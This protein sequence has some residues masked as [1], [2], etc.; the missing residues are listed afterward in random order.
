MHWTGW[1]NNG[2]VIGAISALL[3]GIVIGLLNGLDDCVQIHT[4]S[5]RFYPNQGLKNT[6]HTTLLK[7]GL[8]G[9]SV[10]FITGLIS[11]LI[12]WVVEDFV[13]GIVIG[14]I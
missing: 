7:V 3:F 14:I 2:L 10:G 11:G 12:S 13:T 8:Y 1:I 6:R 9:L 4:N 5:V